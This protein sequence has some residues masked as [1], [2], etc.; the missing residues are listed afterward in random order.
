[1]NER[2]TT[3]LPDKIYGDIL[4][5]ILEGEY[6]E[7]QRLP[8]EHALAERFSTSRPTVREALARLRADG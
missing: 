3:G 7:G 4:N 1:M 2:K 6:K 5:R 8:T